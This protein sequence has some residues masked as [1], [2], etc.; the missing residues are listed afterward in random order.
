MAVDKVPDDFKEIWWLYVD[1]SDEHLPDLIMF[2]KWL[3]RT[4]LVHEGFS[5]S[6]GK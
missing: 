4:A 6:K 3:S 2:E 1:D 5:A